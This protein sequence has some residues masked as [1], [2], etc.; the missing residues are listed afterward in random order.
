MK[1]LVMTAVVGS[2]A[3]PVGFAL[4]GGDPAAGKEKSAVC[5]GC[6]GVG[7]NSTNPQYPR[8]AHQ[9]EDYLIKALSDYKSG[10]RK[11]AIMNGFAAQLSDRDIQNL[12]AYYASQRKGLYVK[13]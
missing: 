5:Q 9:Y 12:A 6:H 7:G 11:N 3:F 10:A 4:A 1:R 8:L 2:L 13:W